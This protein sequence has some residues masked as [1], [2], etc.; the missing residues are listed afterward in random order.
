MRKQHDF[1]E[2]T[3]NKEYIAQLEDLV[4]TLK[5]EKDRRA[6][7]SEEVLSSILDKIST[8]NSQSNQDLVNE[9]NS[10]KR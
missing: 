10:L 6:N 5:K 1:K 3:T 4:D 7:A 9:I 8:I 2:D